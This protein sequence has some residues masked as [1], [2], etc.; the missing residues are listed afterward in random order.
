MIIPVTI[1]LPA[2]TTAQSVRLLLPL[3][4]RDGDAWK[5][6]SVIASKTGNCEALV[7]VAGSSFDWS[8]VFPDVTLFGDDV[9]VCELS[10]SSSIAQE[11]YLGN[12]DIY[13]SGVVV[14]GLYSIAAGSVG[15][16][17]TMSIELEFSE[18]TPPD[19]IAVRVTQQGFAFSR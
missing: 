9:A 10:N 14:I 17:D 12:R 18:V 3:P 1:A 4:E 13:M 2:V 19:D 6:E 16:T 15:V 7:F 11:C 8:S 5:L